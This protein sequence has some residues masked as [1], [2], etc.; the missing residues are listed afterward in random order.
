VGIP[1]C[2][3]GGVLLAV[4]VSGKRAR[5]VTAVRKLREQIVAVVDAY[6]QAGPLSVGTGGPQV[7]EAAWELVRFL[8]DNHLTRGVAV[9]LLYPGKWALQNL[10]FKVFFDGRFLGNG[11]LVQGF[12]LRCK[13][14]VGDH[15]LRVKASA[16]GSD[17]RFRVQLPKEGSCQVEL[18][19]APFVLGT[20]A[21]VTYTS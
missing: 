14:S 2:L 20:V 5:T 7:E 19:N 17:R 4:S 8:G 10:P 12:D 18:T 16:L 11:S 9:R 15:V 13:A 3:F 21:D 1:A 6:P